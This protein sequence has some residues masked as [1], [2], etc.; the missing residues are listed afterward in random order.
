MIL[1]AALVRRPVLG[2]TIAMG[3]LLAVFLIAVLAYRPS[4]HE[5]ERPM[6][7]ASPFVTA[8]PG[9]PA[10]GE[11]AAEVAA[12]FG[13]A[14]FS[15]GDVLP[16]L[17]SAEARAWTQQASEATPSAATVAGVAATFEGAAADGSLAVIVDAS[18]DTSEEAVEV[19]VVDQNGHYL[20]A[21]VSA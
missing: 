8:A 9:S 2:V 7:A 17:T 15:G 11:Q 4:G 13:R 16:Y 14:Y 6:P 10:P 18:V 19:F 21:R 20:V 12:S 3:G 5:D 1:L